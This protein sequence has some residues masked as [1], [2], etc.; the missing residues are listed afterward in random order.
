MS[1]DNAVITDAEFA[2]FQALIYKIAGISLSDAKKVLL[3][4][5][6]GKRLKHFGVG[7]YTE[8]YR[9][10]TS[11]REEAELQ[12]M[13][14]LLTTNETYFFREEKHFDFLAEHILPKHPPGIAF[15][16]WSAASSSGEEVYTLCMVLAERF[17]VGGNW[18]VTG[19]DISQRVLAMAQRGLYPLERTRGIPP[20]LLRKYCLKGVRSQEGMLLIEPA[21]RKHTR[22]LK[23]NLNQKLPELGPFDVIFLR[24]VMIYFDNA[25]KQEVVSR[26]VRQL[27]PGGHFIVGHSESLNGIS[28]EL[29]SVQPTIYVKP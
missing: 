17:G 26:L 9:L 1:V 16:I 15:N 14:D 28:D 10:V 13:V 24:N 19:S 4:G 22:F 6:L 21:L 2:R 11:G 5:R 25:T 20:E 7:T 27:R 18:T 12:M 29:R 23:V 8:Y 3:T